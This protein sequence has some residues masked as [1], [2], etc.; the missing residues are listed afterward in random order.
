MDGFWVEMGEYG[1]S[2]LS[3]G[4]LLR[5]GDAALPQADLRVPMPGAHLLIHARDQDLHLVDCSQLPPQLHTGD[6]Q[7]LRELTV[8]PGQRIYYGSMLLQ[9]LQEGGE[10]RVQ[11]SSKRGD[12]S[13]GRWAPLGATVMGTLMLAVVGLG[14]EWHRY[15]QQVTQMS[16]DVADVAMSML[17]EACYGEGDPTAAFYQ[18]TV[19][20]Q[21]LDRMLPVGLRHQGGKPQAN[22]LTLDAADSGAL[23]IVGRLQPP[24]VLHWIGVDPTLLACEPFRP[25]LEREQ[26]SE[27]EPVD[28]GQFAEEVGMALPKRLQ[29]HGMQSLYLYNARRYCGFTWP[30]RQLAQGEE[31]TLGQLVQKLA[32]L[33]QLSLQAFPD[34]QLERVL[35]DALTNLGEQETFEWELPPQDPWDLPSGRKCTSSPV[36]TAG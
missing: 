11:V 27:V 33:P 8:F 32:H 4:E 29:R 23:R 1:R 7:G 31:S 19:R 5:I 26:K 16:L 15:R 6:G 17:A 14:W 12:R 24:V 22:L 35:W 10:P 3:R 36:V 21:W 18:E 20:E 28:W 30:L 2:P 9:I 13:W 25:V 34:R